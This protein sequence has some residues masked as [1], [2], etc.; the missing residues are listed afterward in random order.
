MRHSLIAL[1]AMLV[2]ATGCYTVDIAGQSNFN[3]CVPSPVITA[4]QGIS[5]FRQRI[6]RQVAVAPADSILD[7]AITFSSDVVQADRDRIVAY[8]GTNIVN[9]PTSS[10]LEAELVAQSLELYVSQD[11]T[12]RLSDVTIFDPACTTD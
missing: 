1:I 3:G 5:D 7:V 11:T 9:G 10:S 2:F 4:G 12:M 6:A 8:G